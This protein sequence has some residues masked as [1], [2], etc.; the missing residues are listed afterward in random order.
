LARH[1]DECRVCQ[2]PLPIRVAADNIQIHSEIGFTWEHS[3]HQYYRRAKS[4][5][6]GRAHT[7]ATRLAAKPPLAVQATVKA[8]WDSLSMTVEA[9]RTVPL[10]YTQLINTTSNLDFTPSSERTWEVR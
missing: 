4:S 3:A 1:G 9:A 7:L 2:D 10:M 5:E 8:V 6:T